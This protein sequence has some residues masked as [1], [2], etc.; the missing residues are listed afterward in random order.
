MLGIAFSG[1]KDSLACWFLFKHMNPIVI[2]VNTGKSYPETRKI[3]DM[4]KAESV[5]FIEAKSNQEL[6]AQ[7]NGLPSDLVP[8]D[9]TSLGMQITGEKSVKI[10]SYMGC[11]H[12]NV[13]RPLMDCA[14]KIGITKLI[15]GQRLDD[16][17]KSPAKNGDIFEGIEFIQ[18]IENWSKNE[19][20]AY[21]EKKM[22]IPEHLHLNHSSLDC[23]DCTAY[24]NDSKDRVEWMK[25][26]HPDLYD[27]YK[28]KADLLKEA[29]SPYVISL[30]L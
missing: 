30:G 4:V 17:H 1:G 5:N 11:C 18:P 10:Q 25:N 3:I 19:V 7:E 23:Y 9:C 20:Y 16:A 27:K 6:H 15:R 29:I 22:D 13:S 8:I 14:K 12:D 24:I 2:W 26:T 28:I 21:L